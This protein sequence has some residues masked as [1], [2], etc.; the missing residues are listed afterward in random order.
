MRIL[1]ISFILI[2]IVPVVTSADTQTQNFID[3]MGEEAEIA[4]IASSVAFGTAGMAFAVANHIQIDSDEKPSTFWLA[5]GY[6]AG[7]LNVALGAFY[8]VGA[9]LLTRNAPDS[10]SWLWAGISH[11]VVGGTGIGL[12]IWGGSMPDENAT[13]V[14]IAPMIIPD[15]E[16]NAAIG[17]GL[18]LVDW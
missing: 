13:S 4:F 15:A 18:R 1:R 14:S 11:L 17:V 7:G 8:V 12:A 5:G 3:S 2:M 16:G 9:S 10:E 6:V